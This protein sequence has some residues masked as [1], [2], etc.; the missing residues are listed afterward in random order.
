MTIS[1]EQ[2][3]EVSSELQ[4]ARSIADLQRVTDA[5]VRR[6]S[7]YK[8]AWVGWIDSEAPDF[9]RVI[10]A[11]ANVQERIWETSPLVPRATDAMIAE[12]EQGRRPV[13]VLDARTDPRTNKEMVERFGNRTIV[14]VPIV[15]G[16]DVKGMLGAGSFGD[17]GVIAPSEGEL[18][19]LT[20]FATLLAPA[21]DR[22]HALA[23][24]A[25]AEQERHALQQHLE[26]L[27]RVEL[28]GVL[29]AGVAHDLNNL[30]AIA[31]ASLS[32]LEQRLAGADAEALG[33]AT[34]ALERMHGISKQLLQLG[35]NRSGKRTRVDLNE[36]V[37]STLALVRRSV[38]AT[39]TV[40]QEHEGLPVVMGDPVQLEQAVANLVI[41][42][43]D[44]VGARGRIEVRIDEKVVGPLE[45]ESRAHGGREGRFA[46]LRVSDSGPGIPLELQG[47]VFDPLYT[48][49]PRGTGIGL[50]VVSRIVQQHDGFVA[51]ESVPPQ[52][53]TFQLY[54]PSLDA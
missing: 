36:V 1:V 2:I 14:N 19:A 46:R 51:V 32:M 22:V 48:T 47:R 12:I 35:T 38:P 7:R 10:T 29:A 25:K 8:A 17:E 42:A 53:A 34:A 45:P 40:V 11:S 41:N 4:H 49:K 3:L 28:M 15:L 30:L 24:Q 54:L 33:D 5:A 6:L 16:G 20:V 31:F 43:R 44:A 9:L 18:E 52:G 50:A 37:R 21:F 13:V 27:Q 26:S 23:A 39:V